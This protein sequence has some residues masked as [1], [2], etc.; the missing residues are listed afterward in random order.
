MNAIAER[1]SFTATLTDSKPLIRGV[2]ARC[3]VPADRFNRSRSTL[4]GS[5]GTAIAP[6][7]GVAQSIAGLG[8]SGLVSATEHLA[9]SLPGL[10]A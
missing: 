5:L 8:A 2:A 3:A 6:L 4:P 9:L 1:R 10:T 7:G